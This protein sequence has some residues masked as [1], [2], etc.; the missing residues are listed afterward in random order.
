[1][2]SVLA[3][4]CFLHLNLLLGFDLPLFALCPSGVKQRVG[5]AEANELADCTAI[6]AKRDIAQA[7]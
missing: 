7:M 5:G 1:M 4:H 2:P 6:V 3:R